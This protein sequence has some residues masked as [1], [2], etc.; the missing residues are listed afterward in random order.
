[1]PDKPRYDGIPLDI[2]LDNIATA[3]DLDTDTL[4]DYAA[5]DTVGGYH[6]SFDDGF[7]VGSMWRVE[8][9]ILYALVRIA[10]P[11]NVLELGTSRGCSATHILTALTRNEGGFLDCVDNGSQVQAI[12]D[13]IP[14]HF[15]GNYQIHNMDMAQFIASAPDA[16]YDLIL[17]DGMHE[18]EQVEMVWRAAYRLLRP[19]GV[20]LSHDAE[21]FLVGERVR[22]G[23]ARAGYFGA[24]PPARTV[25][26]APS[27]CGYAYWRKPLEETDGELVDAPEKPK[28]KRTKKAT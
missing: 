3:F 8:G 14:P 27:D 2:A 12:G 13:L 9:Q 17:E 25:L 5:E 26:I 24:I 20:I 1:M 11:L 28:R 22:E 10:K 21:H 16:S 23:I 7:P 18:P 6:A 19:G 15:A 4:I